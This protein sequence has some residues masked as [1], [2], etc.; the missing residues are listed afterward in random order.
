MKDS[1]HR[2]HVNFWID[3][4]VRGCAVSH[5]AK[6]IRIT[7]EPSKSA[8]SAEL[9]HENGCTVFADVGGCEGCVRTV[10]PSGPWPLAGIEVKD[11]CRFENSTGET[12]FLTI[13][14]VLARPDEGFQGIRPCHP[15]ASDMKEIVIAA[16]PSVPLS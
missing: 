14:P 8:P 15:I 12:R 2:R 9:L 13:V 16:E 11:S 10:P 6:P 3:L 7:E 1:L 4:I 5:R